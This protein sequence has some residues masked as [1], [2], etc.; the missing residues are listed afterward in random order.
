MKPLILVVINEIIMIGKKNWAHGLHIRKLPHIGINNI[1]GGANG[2]EFH[3]KRTS[4]S[5]S[6]KE[7]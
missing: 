5:L 6:K 7:V 2:R 4:I 3:L 1:K